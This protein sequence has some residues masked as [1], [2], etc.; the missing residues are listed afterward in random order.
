MQDCS[1]RGFLARAAA[2][3][4]ALPVGAAMAEGYPSRPIR[5]ITPNSAGSSVDNLARRVGN[6]LNRAWGVPVVVENIAGAGGIIG[7]EKLI[8]APADG[9]TL[10]IVAKNHVILPLVNPAVRYDALAQVTP[11]CTIL[12]SCGV[13]AARPGFPAKTAAEMIAYAKANP[14]K[15][16][17]GTSGIG[18]SV[19]LQGRLLQQIG[20]IEVVNVAYRGVASLVPD[21]MSGMVDVAVFGGRRGG[22]GTC[23]GGG[24]ARAR[25]RCCSIRAGWGD[26]AC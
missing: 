16:N 6:H 8:A 12:E 25:R 20:G 9:L 4:T 17:F 5:I 24:A 13:L 14:G 11:V 15:V 7:T 23:W 3:S 1:R 2:L 18:T 10:A 26:S 22:R 21:L 19:D